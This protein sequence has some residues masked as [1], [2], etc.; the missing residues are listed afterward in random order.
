MLFG[1]T[2]NLSSPVSDESATAQ[3]ASPSA[4]L[5]SYEPHISPPTEAGSRWLPA[6]P[7]SAHKSLGPCHQPPPFPAGSS[8]QTKCP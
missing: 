8:M 1:V 4:Q 2:T 6:H 7:S 5:L 3:H